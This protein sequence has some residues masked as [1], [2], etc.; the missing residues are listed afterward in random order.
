MK[1]I[2]VG[3]ALVLLF[4]GCGLDDSAV[5][6]TLTNALINVE[7]VDGVAKRVCSP[8][9]GIG[10]FPV[11]S[12]F[13]ESIQGPF[14]LCVAVT[15]DVRSS[16]AFLVDGYSDVE[17]R[18]SEA[19]LAFL[20]YDYCFARADDP[21]VAAFD[22]EDGKSQIFKCEDLPLA[23]QRFIPISNTI[24]ANSA[25][26]MFLPVLDPKD[27][28]TLGMG[29]IAANQLGDEV[30]ELNATVET[31]SLDP[32]VLVQL[33]VHAKIAAT[34]R[35]VKS[36]WHHAA[37]QVRRTSAGL[38]PP[39]PCADKPEANALFIPVPDAFGD[40]ICVPIVTCD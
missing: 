16:P 22:S 24:P 40:L 21:V 1:L 33:R 15:S 34:G 30:L 27:I 14:K 31:L 6:V 35:V 25:V 26:G 2:G 18:T 11:F 5:G 9:N 38:C 20:G 37:V 19:S 3:C 7:Q 13:V 4:S 36:N 29:S 23:N 32:N 39:E 28:E 8:D 12:H 10:I 17:L